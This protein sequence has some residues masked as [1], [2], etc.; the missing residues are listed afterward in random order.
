MPAPASGAVERLVI[1]NASLT[2]V[3]TDPYAS[4]ENIRRLADDLGG[5]V[6]TSSLYTT[7][8]ENGR[9]VP[10]GS[11]TIRVP[12]DQ[13]SAAL[14]AIKSQTDEVRDESVSGQDITAEYIDLQARLR[15]LQAAEAQLETLMSQASD[16]QDVIAIFDQLTY[17]REQIEQVKGQIQ[18]YEQAAALSS[19]SIDLLAAEGVLPLEFGGWELGTQARRA[20]QDLVDF[21]RG[22]AYFSVRLVIFYLPVLVLLALLSA[23]LWRYLLRPV[24]RKIRPRR[25][26]AAP[27]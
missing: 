23:T 8:S 25:N 14:Q 24:W 19:I 10:A 16:M 6:V 5:Y 20:L 4:A 7:I 3:V 27:Q 11:L 12:S 2:L 22:L 15:S 26:H 13:L 21:L 1:R 18:Y 17:Y 9:R